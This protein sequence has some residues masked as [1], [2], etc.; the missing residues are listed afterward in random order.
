MLRLSDLPRLSRPLR[1][2]DLSDLGEPTTEK[3]V[4]AVDGGR[5][6]E[7]KQLARYVV[8][9]GKALHD[10]FCDW[11]WNLF[12]EIARRQGETEMHAVM[13]K[14]QETWMMRRTWKGYLKLSVEERVQVT[15]EVMRSH[16]GGPKQQGEIDVV[17]EGDRYSIY[18]DP[19]GSG[20]RMRRGDPVDGT[21][22]RLG[23]P[24]NF[25]KTE[26]A[27]D[28]SWGQKDVPYYCLHCCLNELLPM[29][30]GGHPLW[31]TGY[32]PDAS[33]PCAWHFYKKAEL[34]PD[35]Y[36]ERVGRTKPE[37]GAY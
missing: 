36:Y 13:R 21:P 9:E 27:H 8:T 3:I 12:T 24:Y 10:L 14:S 34:I 2:D 5:L 20:G 32:D 25:G 26:E 31:V 6:A 19:C 29:E 18:M 37:S 30:W 22:S 11:I 35:Q 33:K 4:Q 28:W 15:A 17:D 7:A 16:H 1:Q 23:A